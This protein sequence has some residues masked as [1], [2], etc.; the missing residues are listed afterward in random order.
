MHDS[1]RRAASTTQK[2]FTTALGALFEPTVSGAWCNE[3]RGLLD[4]RRAN[5]Q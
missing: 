5:I 1:T 3:L 4:F 2:Q